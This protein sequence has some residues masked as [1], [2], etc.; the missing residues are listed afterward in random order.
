MKMMIWCLGIILGVFLAQGSIRLLFL[1]RSQ[2]QELQ[3]IKDLSDYRVIL[4]GLVTSQKVALDFLLIENSFIGVL[5]L[6]FCVI[7]I[8]R[9][10]PVSDLESRK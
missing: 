8:F 2:M 6:V 3:N 5:L 9:M 10:P 1:V 7:G 4:T